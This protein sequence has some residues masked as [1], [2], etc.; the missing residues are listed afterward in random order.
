MSN[1]AER[2]V[3][4]AVKRE[5]RSLKQHFK[6]DGWDLDWSCIKET[7]FYDAFGFHLSDVLF[8]ELVAQKMELK[9]GSRDEG[10]GLLLSKGKKSKSFKKLAWAIDIARLFRPAKKKSSKRGKKKNAKS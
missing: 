10:G 1:R 7:I 2:A 4:N 5:V 3:R 6:K 8:R 9:L